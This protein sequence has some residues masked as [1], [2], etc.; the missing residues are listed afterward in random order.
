MDKFDNISGFVGNNDY[1]ECQIHNINADSFTNKDI[2][3]L[4]KK[5]YNKHFGYKKG[6]CW[7]NALINGD[8]MYK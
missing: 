1:N 4:E 3:V 7:H 8:K 6:G 5:G 2:E